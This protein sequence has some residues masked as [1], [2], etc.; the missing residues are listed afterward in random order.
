MTTNTKDHYHGKNVELI[1]DNYAL[2]QSPLNSLIKRLKQDLVTL[3][4]YDSSQKT[5]I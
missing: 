3:Q 2:C 4:E 5:R 1:P